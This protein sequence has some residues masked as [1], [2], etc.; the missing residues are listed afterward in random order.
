[1]KFS[2]SHEWV[3]AEGD[4]AT[5]GITAHAQKELGEVVYVQFPEVGQNVEAG[6]EAVVVESTKAAADIYT[7]VSGTVTAINEAVKNDPSLLN[8]SPE[9]EGWL[10]KI[11]LSN[12]SELDTLLDHQQYIG[13]IS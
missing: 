6:K 12:P 10:I 2:D 9:K 1:M 4:I 13:L 11:A 5:I 7:P 8:A 3:L